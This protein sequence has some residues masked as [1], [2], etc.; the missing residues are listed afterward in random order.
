MIAFWTEGRREG[1]AKEEEGCD[2]EKLT[3]FSLKQENLSLICRENSSHR[4]RHR[5]RDE[6]CRK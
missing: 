4:E 5:E 3:E 2:C 6:M 1:E